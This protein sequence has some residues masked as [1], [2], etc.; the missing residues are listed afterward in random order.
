MDEEDR[1]VH[2][3]EKERERE[4]TNENKKTTKKAPATN[5]FNV[6]TMHRATQWNRIDFLPLIA[7]ASMDT[8][9]GHF[10]PILLPKNKYAYR[11]L[12]HILLPR[13]SSSSFRVRFAYSC[14]G[15]LRA[16]THIRVTA[17]T[18]EMKKKTDRKKK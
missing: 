9:N 7:I 4:K 17:K 5:Y 8:T 1:N 13:L 18:N 12:V 11:H 16:H 14:W 10:S 15:F 6:C 3:P 2:T